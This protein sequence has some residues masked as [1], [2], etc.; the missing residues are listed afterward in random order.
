MPHEYHEGQ[1]E[2]QDR[3]DTRRLADRL[4]DVACDTFSEELARFVEARD[5]FFI[6][7]TDPDGS[8][9]CSYKGGDPG[10]VRVVDDDDARVPGLRRQRHVPHARQPAR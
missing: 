5:M 6:A 8:P 3:F 7:S 4:A 9:D 10:F 1:R 2:L